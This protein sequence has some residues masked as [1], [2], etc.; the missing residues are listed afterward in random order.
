[1]RIVNQGVVIT[2][3][4]IN[5]FLCLEKYLL[6]QF[7]NIIIWKNIFIFMIF[8]DKINIYIYLK[9]IVI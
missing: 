4:L 5:V 9:N 8:D 7:R 6:K 2:M 1:M 3:F